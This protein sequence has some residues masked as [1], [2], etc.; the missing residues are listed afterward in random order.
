MRKEFP[1]LRLTVYVLCAFSF[2]A[3]R[4]NGQ[5]KEEPKSH[6]NGIVQDW[7]RR[8]AVYPRVGP[9]HSLISMQNDP[10]AVLSWQE[11]ARQDWH[12]ERERWHFRGLRRGRLH[13]D[14]NIRLSVSASNVISTSMFP[15][16]YGFNVS[17]APDCANDIIAF[18]VNAGFPVANIAGN[19]TSTSVTVTITAGTIT[20][21]YVGEP[22]T[23]TGMPAGATIATVTGSPATSITL[24]AAATAS[25]SQALTVSGQPNLVVFNNLYSGTTP[26]AGLCNRTPS[27]IDNGVSATVFAS[28]YMH[29]RGGQI[30]TSPA[31]SLDGTRLAVVETGPGQAALFEVIGPH[32]G[33]GV[34]PNNAQ[35]A[36]LPLEINSFDTAAPGGNAGSASAL[37]FG[38]SPDSISSPFVDYI[39]DQAYVGNDTG[40]LFRIKDVFCAT[41]ICQ[42]T[43]PNRPAPSLDST[44]G[45]AGGL[46]TGCPGKLTGPVVDFNTGN[47]F[48]GCSNGTVYGF[49]PAGAALTGS[50]I[51]V[52][53]TATNGGIVDPPLVDVIHGDLYVASANNG[54]NCVVA[55]IHD[56]GTTMSLTATAI[57]D[58]VGPGTSGIN[59]HAPAFNN[60]YFTSPTPANWLLYEYSPNT[61]TT[62][63][64]WGIGFN[65]G[66][67]M[68]SGTPSHLQVISGGGPFEASPLTT[69]FNGSVD[70]LFVGNTSPSPGDAGI[71]N[72]VITGGSFPTTEPTLFDAEGEG[73][74]GI[75]VD[76]NDVIDGQTSSIYFG[77]IGPSGV[78]ANSAVK[79]TQSGLQ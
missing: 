9:L 70:Y 54:T 34:D 36:L 71:V 62:T 48:V 72:F 74:S 25:G 67:A 47:I 38:S 41:T 8:Y 53:S 73:T 37:T 68:I 32:N 66:H 61:N 55:Q 79:L 57:L 50:P 22:I 15:A 18:P 4:A 10:R 58:S 63:S 76:N 3:V 6:P 1:F 12:R 75:V 52:G 5:G 7:S 35:N 17:A 16:K 65:A 39:T 2:L 64:V 31:L 19:L 51:T 28:Y 56:S 27:G 69:F 40:T 77:V 30:S 24:S 45:T 43:L 23:G 21:A 78:N 20:P 59:L 49:T 11:A 26:T 46:A 33:D 42:N 44:W 14:W 60:D 13:Q 29:A